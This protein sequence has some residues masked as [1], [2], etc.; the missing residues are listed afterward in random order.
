MVKA[1]NNYICSAVKEKEKKNAKQK[2]VKKEIREQKKE[3]YAEGTEGMRILKKNFEALGDNDAEDEALI[4]YMEYKSRVAGWKK[5]IYKLLEWTGEYGT[6]PK[7]ILRWV[8]GIWLFAS[9][10]FSIAL[11]PDEHIKSILM[12]LKYNSCN[13]LPLLGAPSIV[14]YSG[15]RAL[16][17]FL[18]CVGE[19]VLETVLFGYFAIA[20]VRKTMR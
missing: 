17:F 19:C 13:I 7:K 12:S 18:T 11:W 14:T 9:I 1:V 8:I 10:L 5:V 20:I 15:S 3:I 16:L 6:S 2:A 4:G